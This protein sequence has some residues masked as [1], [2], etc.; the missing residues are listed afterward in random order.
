MLQH[1]IINDGDSKDFI[2]SI[3]SHL[4]WSQEELARRLGVSF[5]SVNAWAN[6]R[7]VPRKSTQDKIAALCKEFADINDASL[8]SRPAIPAR[9]QRLGIFFTTP[10]DGKANMQPYI[11]TILTKLRQVHKVITPEDAQEYQS[12]L[13][14]LQVEGLNKDQ[15]HYAYIRQ[16]IAS[17]DVVIIEAT[18]EDTR[19]GHELTLALLYNKPTLVLSRGKNLADFIPH[20]LLTGATY[21]SQSDVH[22][23]L[24]AYLKNTA[25]G[26]GDSIMQTLSHNSDVLHASALAPLRR[27]ARQEPGQ[28]GEWARRAESHSAEVAKDIQSSLGHIKQQEAWSV[29]APIY[30]EDSP[31][32][33]QSGVAAFVDRQLRIHNIAKDEV[34]IE[35]ACGTGALARQ[36]V[37]AG[38]MNLTAFDSS[39]PMLAEAYRLCASIPEITLQEA[40]IRSYMAT[41]PA[42]AIVWSDYSSNFALDRSELT[43]MLQQLLNNVEPGGV[44]LFDIRTF[45]GWQVDFYAQPVTLFATERFQRIWLNHQD[46]KNGLID[47]DVFVR[48]RAQDGAWAPWRRESMREKMWRMQEILEVIQSLQGVDTT[49]LY[50]DDFRK[51][52]STDN[53][54]GLMYVVLRRS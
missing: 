10:Y 15:A 34:V 25:F 16:G 24:D 19:V 32:Y 54:P 13:V 37:L 42:R 4:G 44:L 46:H 6:G 7:S 41:K 5:A 52:K 27:L 51:L 18:T 53:E 43:Q 8:R 3:L 22:A 49:Q 14:K 23:I 35:A 26:L 40:D 30:N 38:Y 9:P 1:H 17:A 2:R 11:D 36:L 47:F 48:V 33:I 50:A 28:F 12:T 20:D 29:F 21:S 39:R 31:D 45:T